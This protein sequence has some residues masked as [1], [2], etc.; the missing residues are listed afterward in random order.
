MKLERADGAGWRLWP[1]A[2]ACCARAAAPA[3]VACAVLAPLAVHWL[4]GRTLVW[5]D[6]QRLYAPERW[7]VDEAL[8]GF[9][10]PLWNPFMS[11]G[12]P[13]FADGIHGV[14][15]PVSVLTAWLGTG[16]S[17]DLLVGGYVICAGLGAALLARDLGASRA[18]AAVAAFAF[19]MSGF[20]QSMAG[21]LV[22]LAGAGSLP[23]CVAGLRR[24]AVEPRP[25]QLAAGAGGALLLALSGDF[26][27][28]IVGGGL[29][30]V[31]AWEV[32][33]WRGAARAVAA[34][35]VGLLLAAVQLVPTAVHLSRSER[36]VETWNRMPA[37]WALEPWRVAEL[38]LPGLLWGPDPLMDVV[39]AEL[40]GPGRW[41]DGGLP[42][43]FVASVF[44]GV[45]PVALAVAGVRGGRR[46]RLLGLVALVLLW[47]ALGPA[48]GADA[49][50]SHVPIWRSF[51][52]A[53]KLVGPLTLVVA[54]LAG[55]GA[56]EV[57]ARRVTG[58]WLFAV[59]V[60]IGLVSVGA[61]F[62]AGSRLTP[63]VAAMARDR[64]LRGAWH[65]LC[66]AGA[67]GGW[68]LAGRRLGTTGREVALAAVVWG[69][70]AAASPAALRPGDP[71]ARLRSPGPA[72]AATPPGPRIVTP[73]TYEP[74][75]AGPAGD[76]IDQAA[77]EHASLGMVAHNVRSRIDAFDDYGA[78]LPRRPALLQAAFG[79]RWP[80]AARRYGVT[81]V[82]VYPPRSEPHRALHA[83][84]TSGGTRVHSGAGP[85]EV[86]SVPHREWASFPPEVRVVEGE[87]AAVRGTAASFI[88]G[89]PAV[90]IE[91]PSRFSA[92]AGRVL[93]IA[94]GLESVRIEAG[95][96]ADATLVVADAWWPGWEATLDGLPV[97]IFRADVLVRAVRWPAGRH[98]LEMRYRPPEVRTGIMVSVLGI[99]VL[100]GWITI[101]RR[102]PSR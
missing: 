4:A 22:F 18:G 66:A 67:L 48:L 16:W 56:D 28:L 61:S 83:L 77:R 14:L 12:T 45:V 30:L 34:G 96:E 47:I 93:S 80:A 25:A 40:A 23:F 57:V 3:I 97:P 58:R 32:G 91:A 95:S 85:G 102:A 65:V 63:D 78:M 9:R 29:A 24:F 46:G 99:A 2:R 59:A 42:L 70:M 94:R 72:L 6:T 71:A 51:R 92:A 88:E 35:S 86:W 100:A 82:V 8:R 50:L 64:V 52:Y 98:V 89:S 39:Y 26:E 49:L 21:N 7:L 37:V 54:A 84:A 44:V 27:S 79:P 19:A 69:A 17:A 10:L 81:H 90:V 87:R 11:G 101:S 43:P 73:Y 41:M 20:V 5:F 74:L 15:H 55:L 13:L 75:S 1:G 38:V 36:A 31:L 60:A 53:E 62:V 76:W 68:I 33:G